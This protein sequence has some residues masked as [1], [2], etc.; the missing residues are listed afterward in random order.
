[1]LTLHI[2]QGLPSSTTYRSSLVMTLLSRLLL[3]LVCTVWT[4]ALTRAEGD[5]PATDQVTVPGRI[6][7]VE[8]VAKQRDGNESTFMVYYL[9]SADNKRQVLRN[10]AK[11]RGAGPDAIDLAAYLDKQVVVTMQVIDKP[12][13]QEGKAPYMVRTV[14]RI[15]RIVLVGAE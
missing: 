1:M 7:G 15:D 6:V 14:V 2:P 12:V 13:K 3:A 4:T 10:P 8:R 9:Q 5:G 11:E